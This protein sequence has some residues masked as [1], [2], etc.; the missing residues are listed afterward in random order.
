M[1]KMNE[2]YEM[3][4]MNEMNE[5]YEYLDSLPYNSERINIRRRNLKNLPS[6][7]KFANIKYLYCDGN[8]FTELNNL[9]N[10]LKYLYCNDN[11]LTEDIYELITCLEI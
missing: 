10:T 9:P 7:N 4:E 3:Y 2:M 11:Q 1:N 5:M 8:Q 6:L